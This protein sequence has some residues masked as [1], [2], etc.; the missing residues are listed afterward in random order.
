MKRAK[1]WAGNDLSKG[2]AVARWFGRLS[3]WRAAQ[4]H[5]GTASSSISSGS[6][7]ASLWQRGLRKK[8]PANIDL[9]AAKRCLPPHAMIYESHSERR[10]RGYFVYGGSRQSSGASIDYWGLQSAL[11]YV[12]KFLWAKYLA[13]DPTKECPFVGLMEADILPAHVAANL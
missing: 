12:L 7:T 8:L 2:K 4:H 6:D 1:E 9:N 13:M 11:T 5:G 10:I 3:E